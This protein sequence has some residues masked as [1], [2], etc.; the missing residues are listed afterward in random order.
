[1]VPVF[2]PVEIVVEDVDGARYATERDEGKQTLAQGRWH[3]YHLSEDQWRKY[4]DVLGPMCRAHEPYE[5]GD[6]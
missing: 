2:V 4:K 5:F 3:V 1:M 6:H